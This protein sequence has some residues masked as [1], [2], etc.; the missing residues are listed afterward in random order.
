MADDLK[1]RQPQ[2]G[3]RINVNEDWEV[4]YWTEALGV[5]KD[6]LKAGSRPSVSRST[7]CDDI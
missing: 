3:K 7:M 5:S 4:E 2:D 1:K 6:Q